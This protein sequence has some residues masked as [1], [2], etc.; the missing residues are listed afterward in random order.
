MAAMKGLPASFTNDYRTAL[1]AAPAIVA[2]ETHPLKFLRCCQ[3][4]PWS[5]AARLCQNWTYRREIFGAHDWCKPMRLRDGALTMEDVDFLRTGAFTILT[6]PDNQRQVIVVNFGRLHG[7]DPGMERR[8]VNFYLCNTQVN[9]YSQRHGISVLMVIDGTGMKVRG[10]NGKLFQASHT[11]SSF[12]IDQVI[13]ANDP[14]ETRHTLTHLFGLMMRRLAEKFWGKQGRLVNVAEGTP[15]ATLEALVAQGLHPSC[16]PTQLGGTFSYDRNFKE[17]LAIR[18]CTEQTEARE[19]SDACH[20]PVVAPL[21][22]ALPQIE[23]TPSSSINGAWE[24]MNHQV[25]DTLQTSSR[26]T[27]NFSIPYP[28]LFNNDNNNNSQTMMMEASTGSLADDHTQN[29]NDSQPPRKRRRKAQP[30]M[31][32]VRQRNCD[33]S[34]KHYYKKKNQV[35][36]LQE[37]CDV[38]VQEQR[39]LQ[40]QNR[41]LTEAMQQAQSMVYEAMGSAS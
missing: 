26:P 8:R 21:P 41:Q 16:I 4:D 11:V 36:N 17:W 12:T 22:V 23:V 20:S 33:Y 6:A 14:N 9:E 15:E 40:D 35:Q 2:T 10:D 1:T 25:M 19:N 5:A 31:D 30:T 34:K 39:R 37:E 38:L 24:E 13:L 27:W 7:Q 32:V 18:I 3:G 29:T 28:Q